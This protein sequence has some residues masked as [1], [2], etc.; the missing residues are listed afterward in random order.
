VL[1]G[2][3]LFSATVA[4]GI[5]HGPTVDFARDALLKPLHTFSEQ[6]RLRKRGER[7]V[8]LA[9][10]SEWL[11]SLRSGEYFRRGARSESRSSRRSSNSDDSSERRSRRASSES[12]SS[13]SR[14]SESRHARS[15]SESS[16]SVKIITLPAGFKIGSGATYRTLCVRLCDGFYWPV[17]FATT[18][19]HI[20]RDA[21]ICKNSCNTPAALY[22]YPNPG[23]EP[24][25]MINTE[26]EFYSQLKTAFL[27]R[28]SYLPSCKCRPNPW[29]KEEKERH[30]AYAR[31]QAKTDLAATGNAAGGD[32]MP[33]ADALPAVPA[34]PRT[35]D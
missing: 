6:L 3:G 35:K 2:S 25:E 26:G 12:R 18:S 32:E 9:D 21:E 13:E 10:S 4:A 31:E 19:K 5:S 22:Y 24:E 8:K 27:Y 11:D 17:N 34:D 15:K 16:G 1:L 30:E 23:G 14:S 20:S 33:G 29:D 28:T 7:R